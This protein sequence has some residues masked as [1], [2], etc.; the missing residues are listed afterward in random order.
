VVPLLVNPLAAVIRLLDPLL[1]VTPGIPDTFTVTVPAGAFAATVLVIAEAPRP[2]PT[3]TPM[4]LVSCRVSLPD[5]RVN[6]P[7]AVGI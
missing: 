2:P 3:A 5:V 6:A 1:T 4:V 7:A